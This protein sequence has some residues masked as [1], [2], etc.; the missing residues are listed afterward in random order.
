[1]KD[2]FTKLFQ[3]LREKVS[4][5][6]LA[7]AIFLICFALFF[8]F[9]FY[10]KAEYVNIRVK[11]TDQDVL[12]ERTSPM[13]WYANQF[14]VGDVEKDTVGRIISEITNVESFNVEPNKKAVYLDLQ[15]KA[16]YD[17][18]TNTYTAR[19]RKLIYG[20]PMRFNFDTITFDGYVSEY[21]GIDQELEFIQAK[22]SVLG[23]NIEPDLARAVKVGDKIFNSNAHILA[24]V[25]EIDISP[26]EK[27]TQTDRGDLLLR[28]DPLYKDIRLVLSVKTKI[29]QDEYFIFDNQA[30]KIG[31]VI[32]LN[33]DKVSLF[34]IITDFELAD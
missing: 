9:F 17:S 28:Y 16:V 23:R 8:F 20:A 10:R 30:L 24:E 13:S 2:Q 27:V 22:I 12:Y 33:F 26:A 31:Q 6:D 29:F 11:V 7:L 34:L 18:R 3:Q 14:R 1:M 4:V 32:P 5:F 25:I 15:V 19:G 21:P